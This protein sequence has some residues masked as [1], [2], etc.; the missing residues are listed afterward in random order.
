MRRASSWR[1]SGVGAVPTSEAYFF[2]GV[3]AFPAGGVFGFVV[4]ACP[5]PNRSLYLRTTSL[6]RS[7]AAGA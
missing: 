2:G 4:A 6:V 5:V 1:E 7:D 3:A